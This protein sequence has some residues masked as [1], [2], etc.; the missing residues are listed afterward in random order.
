MK[1]IYLILIT[2]LLFNCSAEA[3]LKTKENDVMYYEEVVEINKSASEI[4]DAVEEFLALSSNNS[5]YTIKLNQSDKIISKGVLSVVGKTKL[6][7]TLKVEFKDYK[8]KLLIDPIS[9]SNKSLFT[10]SMHFDRNKAKKMQKEMYLKS[11]LSEKKYQKIKKSREVSKGTGVYSGRKQVTLLQ[12]IGFCGGCGRKLTSGSN[13]S[14]RFYQ[15]RGYWRRY[16]STKIDETLC[17]SKRTIRLDLADE[18][19]WNTVLDVL[20][21]S[22]LYKETVKQAL[23]PDESS[24]KE[25]DSEQS[26]AKKQIKRLTKQLAKVDAAIVSN[27]TNKALVDDTSRIEKVI[28]QLQEQELQLKADIERHQSALEKASSTSQW[29]NWVRAFGE[30]IESLKTAKNMSEEEKNKLFYKNAAKIYKIN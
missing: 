14:S 4:H 1:K 7:V 24:Q 26:N 11:G 5:N 30:K 2:V 27:M 12:D 21:T 23:L 22:H 28:T 18:L 29:I 25:R 13:K 15:C 17:S 19:I 10:K 3:Q 6:G 16:R 20:T 9:W 8:Y